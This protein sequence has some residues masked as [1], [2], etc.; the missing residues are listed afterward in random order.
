MARGAPHLVRDVLEV[1]FCHVLG[2]G[3]GQV[4]RQD[5]AR[6]KTCHMW[7]VHQA[8]GQPPDMVSKPGPGDAGCPSLC[9][10]HGLA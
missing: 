3:E 9:L 6:L 4:S 8:R 5:G 1:V 2:E 10:H 7:T